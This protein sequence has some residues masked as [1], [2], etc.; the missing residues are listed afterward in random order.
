VYII[1][2][3]TN[4]FTNGKKTRGYYNGLN[5]I[6]SK[7]WESTLN[8]YQ[9]ENMMSGVILQINYRF[10]VSREAHDEAVTAMA[11]AIAATPGLQWKVWLM[12]EEGSEA[13]GIYY[14]ESEEAA[15]KFLDSALVAQVLQHPALSDF[16][17]KI[18][19][20]LEKLSRITRAPIG[21]MTPAS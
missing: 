2:P 21:E 13:G 11:D 15:K 8:S 14:F 3:N 7:S 1:K 12:N 6:F 4:A 10:N 19:N 17:V 9:G 20:V 5:C 18:F 16:A